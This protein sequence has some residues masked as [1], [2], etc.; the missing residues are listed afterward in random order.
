MDDEKRYLLT[1]VIDIYLDLDDEEDERFNQEMDKGERKEVKKMIL[2]L[3]EA[4]DDSEA[5]GKVEGKVEEARKAVL[6]VVEHRWGS[7]QDDFVAKLEAI[8]DLDRL[9]EI[10]EQALKV[11]SLDEIDLS[12]GD[13]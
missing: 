5:R 8:D 3:Q 11:S 7:P 9:H 10:L 4:I 6:L 13:S 2:T 12:P 1:N